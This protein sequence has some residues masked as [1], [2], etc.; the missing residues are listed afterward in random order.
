MKKTRPLISIIIP[1]FNE[2]KHIKTCLDSILKQDMKEKIEVL[3]VDDN[4]T[5]NTLNIV[6][7]F[8]GKLNIRVIKNGTK[9][10]ERGKKIGLMSAKGDFFMYLDADMEYRDKDWFNQSMK[11]LI[12]N[13]KIVGTIASFGV[14]KDHNAITRC[15][16]YDVFQR[17]PIFIA[18]TPSIEKTIIKK[19]KGYF[20]CKFEKDEMPAQSL[21]LYRTKIIKKLFKKSYHLMDNDVPII[22]VENGHNL[23]AFCPNVR[24]YHLLLKDLKELAKKRLRGVLKTYT[25]NFSERKYRWF[26]LK[27]KINILKL[28]IWIIV[29][30]L[31]IPGFIYGIYKSIRYKDVACLYEFAINVVSTDSLIYAFFVSRFGFKNLFKV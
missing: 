1:T 8:K 11:P 22:L 15:I 21:C 26:N 13:E 14:K 4:S 25:K 24:I 28:G 6:D 16:S 27:K 3:I 18:F 10:P 5:D 23:F 29:A 31:L 12:K 19:E 9:D 17:D 20:V 30:N 7:S 2:Q